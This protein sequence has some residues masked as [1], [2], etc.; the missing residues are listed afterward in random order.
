M[1]KEAQS[2]FDLIFPKQMRVQAGLS[3][4]E[5]SFLYN[6]WKTAPVGSTSFSVP[7]N[8]DKKHV[9]A[10]KVKGYLSGFGASTELT[11]KGKKVIVEMVTAEPNSFEKQAKDVSYS[12]IKSK[13]AHGR[14]IQ[15]FLKK[16]SKATVPSF[17][18]RRMSLRKMGE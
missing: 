9:S 18:L 15:A 6:M 5:A 16:A 8:A 12:S 10:L 17:N 7:P 11:E 2:L 14:P 1:E 13:S 4:D 3:D